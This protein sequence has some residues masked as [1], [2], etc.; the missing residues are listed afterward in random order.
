MAVKQIAGERVIDSE[1][2]DISEL[3]EDMDNDVHNIFAAFGD[4][5]DDVSYLI[6]VYRI[7]PGTAESPWL[8]NCVP[9]ELPI[10]V[11]LR[12]EFGGGRF[13]IRI[14]RKK[15]GR[16]RLWKKPVMLIEAPRKSDADKP[17]NNDTASI[18]RAMQESNQQMFQQLTTVI[19]Q[20]AGVSEV[21]TNPLGM[22]RDLAA[23]M[24]DLM[25][26]S[27]PAAG[28]SLK[29][30]VETMALLKEIGGGDARGGDTNWMDVVSKLMDSPLLTG[31]AAN[32]HNSQRQLPAP[33]TQPAAQSERPAPEEKPQSEEEMRNYMIKQYVNGLISR[34]QNGQDPGFI[35]ELILNDAK[36]YNIPLDTIQ[37]EMLGSEAIERLIQENPAAAP[38]RGWFAN[39]QL[40]LTRMVNEDLTA[41]G[42]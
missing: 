32:L 14:Y 16:F 25:P 39:V 24:R 33:G 13:E 12:D 22:V 38:Y 27:P 8:F 41:P 19:K 7:L 42:A 36:A 6:K 37:T 20:G 17:Q 30:M 21:Q 5:V 15:E 10:D 9:S 34:A 1:A 28:A 18:L 23:T 3:A 29:D 40:E 4:D 31:L 26:A 11:K 35:A 2:D